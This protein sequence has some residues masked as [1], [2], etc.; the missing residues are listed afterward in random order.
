MGCA[1]AAL[2]L[3]AAV[4]APVV[5]PSAGAASALGPARPAR[6]A[7]PAKS[8]QPLSLP[9]PAH[10]VTVHGPGSSWG[11]GVLGAPACDPLGGQSCMLPFPSDY[12]T[13]PDPK[14]P[15]GRRVDFP[16]D[17]MPA[18]AQGV[19]I[20]PTTWNK[21]DG[22]SPGSV[23]E[24]Q[25]PY[26]DLAASG[27]VDQYH[28][29]G[30]LSPNAP[31]VLLDASTGRRLAWWGEA[32][33]RNADPA[34][35]LL[36]IHPAVNLPEGSRIVV[37][38]RDLRATSGAPIAASGDFAQVL[39]G[40]TVAGPG[41]AALSTHVRSLLDVLQRDA[42][43]SA[44]GLYLA[45]DFTV[46]STANLT[47]PV[48]HMRD[49]AMA[50]L[51]G[52]GK[53]PQFHVT[54]VANVPP[55]SK[56]G[57]AISRQVSGTFDVPSFLNGPSGD[58]TDTLHLGAN[59]LPTV[60]RGQ[61]EVASFACLIPRSVAADPQRLSGAVH[62]GRPVLYGIGLFNTTRGM[63]AE[64]VSGLADRGHLVLCS[65][66]WLGLTGNA[67]LTDVGLF[68][69]LSAFP[70]L[71]DHLMQAMIDALYL[72][73]LMTSSKG[74]VSDAAFRAGSSHRALIDTAVPLTYYGNSEGALMGG[75]VTAISPEWQ[76][77]VL[78][79]PSMNYSI[80][81]PRSVDFAPL[82]PYFDKS[83]PNEQTQELILGLLQM[84]FDRGETDGYVAQLTTYP[85]PG[86]PGHQVLLQMAFGDHQVS[87]FTTEIEARTLGAAVHTPTL[88]AGLVHG[89]PFYGLA[90][91]TADEHAPATLYVWEDPHAPPPPL[92]NEPP[93]A[94]VDPHDFMP[95]DAPDAQRQLLQFL[96]TGRVR[97]VCG[98]SACTSDLAAAPAP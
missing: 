7:R 66:D 9:A 28:I 67:V 87:N 89:D 71:P 79:V 31:I 65:T 80:L 56:D 49:V 27:I 8:S 58:K 38:L 74:F 11:V 50:A 34:T 22:F 2:L 1:L 86:T 10:A 60:N 57:K 41:G 94:G 52:K 70:S 47:G 76:R 13:V 85:L 44:A 82:Y 55:S 72:G 69:N 88:P 61:T 48:L 81:L 26:L 21:N 68:S 53:T 18:N 63:E 15:S 29:A 33:A 25:V 96:A 83:Y 45:W 19:H 12:Y 37:A 24:V 46:I 4:C 23:I 54:A 90:P 84:L 97:D 77:A 62:P 35:R 3:L 93:S 91:A 98:H 20:D 5:V 36:L 64:N 92:V 39:A 14:E 43:V 95:R 32:D 6:P 42:S 75:A 78:G 40:K 73:K 17:A 51:D 16:L 59:G 30:S